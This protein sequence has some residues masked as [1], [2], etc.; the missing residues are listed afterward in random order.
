V[1]ESN[2]AEALNPATVFLH[3]CYRP[4]WKLLRAESQASLISVSAFRQF[5]AAIPMV[6]VQTYDHATD[7]QLAGSVW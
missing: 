5:A 6:A 4:L 7:P 3:G 2:D 1:T